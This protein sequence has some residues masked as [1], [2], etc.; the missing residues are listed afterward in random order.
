MVEAEDERG[1]EIDKYVAVLVEAGG[2]N[3][4]ALSSVDIPWHCLEG[5]VDLATDRRKCHTRAER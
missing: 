4:C 2:A 3:D 5:F 1:A